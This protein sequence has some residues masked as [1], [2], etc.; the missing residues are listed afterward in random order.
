MLCSVIPEPPSHCLHPFFPPGQAPG[1]PPAQTLLS[2]PGCQLPNTRQSPGFS[3]VFPAWQPWFLPSP[4]PSSVSKY[5][6]LCC[7]YFLIHLSYP[8]DCEILKDKGH[9][10]FIF[11]FLTALSRM[12]GQKRSQWMWAERMSLSTF[13]A[14][15]SCADSPCLPFL[16]TAPSL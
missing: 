5:I 8:L 15:Q 1:L 3:Y 13:C 7:S 14:S 9:V 2:A 11:V 4:F 16:P 10:L 12:P 6:T